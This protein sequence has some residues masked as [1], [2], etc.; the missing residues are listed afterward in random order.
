[1]IGP[2]YAK[3]LLRDPGG[4]Q[5]LILGTTGSNTLTLPATRPAFS[6]VSVLIFQR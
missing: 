1:M 2:T 4:P 6:E 3:L 5:I